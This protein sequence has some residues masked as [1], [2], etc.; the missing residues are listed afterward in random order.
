MKRYSIK[1]AFNEIILGFLSI[2]DGLVCILTAGFF[3]PSLSSYFA[4]KIFIDK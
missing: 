3:Y 4:F 1:L 2:I